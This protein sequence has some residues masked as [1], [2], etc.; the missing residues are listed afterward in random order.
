MFAV[1]GKQISGKYITL[2]PDGDKSINTMEQSD[3]RKASSFSA[4]LRIRRILSAW[5]FFIVYTTA[6]HSPILS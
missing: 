4:N 6:R 5:S 3:S 2:K 1:F